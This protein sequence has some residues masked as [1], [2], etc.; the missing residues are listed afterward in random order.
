MRTLPLHEL[1]LAAYLCAHSCLLLVPYCTGAYHA[2]FNWGYNA[3]ESVNFA[4]KK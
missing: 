4:T 1:S 3:A 2:G